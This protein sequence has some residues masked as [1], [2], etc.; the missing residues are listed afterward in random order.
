MAGCVFAFTGCTKPADESLDTGYRLT[1]IKQSNPTSVLAAIHKPEEELLSQSGNVVISWGEKRGGK[2]V[3]FN[4]V[5]FDENNL[6]AQRKYFFAVDEK[7]LKWPMVDKEFLR[8]EAEVVL[9]KDVL[10]EPYANNNLRRI[11][12][13]KQI[14]ADFKEDVSEV[15]SDNI[16]IDEASLMVNQMI[17]RALFVLDKSNALATRL[18]TEEGMEIDHP[19]LGK[20]HIWLTTRADV[21]ELK[22]LIKNRYEKWE[23]PFNLTR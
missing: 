14:L 1:V 19:T 7:P 22:V 16:R 10:E 13:I 12:F 15:R 9:D 6:Y 2:Q 4:M 11:G 23:N 3:W 8:L 18:N 5:R 17:G 20:G 21:T